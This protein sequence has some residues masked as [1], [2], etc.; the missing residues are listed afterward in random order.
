MHGRETIFDM[1]S[2]VFFLV[3]DENDVILARQQPKFSMNI[4]IH[5]YRIRI[6][7]KKPKKNSLVNVAL[8][9]LK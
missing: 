4:S 8:V 7:A 5:I 6:Q 2:L 9:F 1:I 3:L